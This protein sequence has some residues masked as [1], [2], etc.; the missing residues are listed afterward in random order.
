MN[1]TWPPL[2]AFQLQHGQRAAVGKGCEERGEM[3]AGVHGRQKFEWGR[4]RAQPSW[5]KEG[6]SEEEGRWRRSCR[7][8]PASIG[9][10]GLLYPR[11][12]LADLS[13]DGWMLGRA[14]GVNAPRK[15]ALQ[16]L[17]TDQRATRVTLGVGGRRDQI[18]TP[19]ER[20]PLGGF[21]Y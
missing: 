20:L 15:D 12:V 17:V 10:D 21:G 13:V 14:A 5:R 7:V 6:K 18:N 8:S 9:A 4:G 2:F 19:T 3:L 1:K 11:A 16:G